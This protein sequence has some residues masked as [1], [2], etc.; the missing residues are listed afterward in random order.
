MNRLLKSCAV[1]LLLMTAIAPAHSQVINPVQKLFPDGTRIHNNIPYAHDTLKRHLL[2][3]YLPASG[4]EF[5]LVVWI[6]G[7]AWNHNSKYSDMGYMRNTVKG[8]IDHGYA[9]ASIDYRYSTEAV[10]PAQL[11]DCNQAIEYVYQHAGEYGINK[12][13]MVTVGFSA[14]GH[15]AS[16]LG[17]STNNHVKDF[18]AAGER[19]SFSLR[20]VIDFYGPSDF[21]ALTGRTVDPF[22]DDD[23]IVKLLGASPLLRPDLAKRASP[24]TY[25]DKHDPPFLIIQGEKDESVPKSQSTLLHQ[26]L[27]DANVKNELIIVPGAP[28]YGEMFDVPE[29]QERVFKFLAEAFR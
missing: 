22:P 12:T 15:L 2:D 13:K 11:Q 4:N 21:L 6:H 27:N 8:F 5:P 19:I 20:G 3:I 26:W 16:I 18:S 23:A 14:G 24:T 28:H 1:S 25:I 29:I 7:G 9:V 10:F 17:L